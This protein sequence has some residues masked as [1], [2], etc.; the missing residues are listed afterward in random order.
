MCN[1]RIGRLCATFQF[2]YTFNL[3][4]YFEIV[5]FS[6]SF[7]F[8]F[9]PFGL[10]SFHVR[11]SSTPKLPACNRSFLLPGSLYWPI[12]FFLQSQKFHNLRFNT[13]KRMGKHHLSQENERRKS[14]K[15]IERERARAH[16]R[17]KLWKASETSPFGEPSF[18]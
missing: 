8:L 14:K 16:E 9:L 2:Y 13:R 15:E 6:L 7:L 1:L 12:F 18:R 10:S 11:C 5:L 3:F 4:R 17:T